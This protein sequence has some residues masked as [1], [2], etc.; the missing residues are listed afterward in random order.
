MHEC[1]AKWHDST[2][3]VSEAK[4][5][6]TA[7]YEFIGQYL[8]VDASD[9]GGGDFLSLAE[10]NAFI[11]AGLQIVS[12]FQK[13]EMSDTDFD[14][15][16]HS[17]G[18]QS[19]LTEA[20]GEADAATAYKAA[21]DE[22]ITAIRHEESLASV[23]HSVAQVDAWEGAYFAAEEARGKARAAKEAYE[24]GLRATLYGID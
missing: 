12:I 15:G 16:A 21:V 10:A 7:G 18:W 23:D 8:G 2:G 4:A 14:T 19:Y 3:A 1:V 11:K 13:P 20:Q 5:L 6:K 22:W 9:A 24:A 17:Y